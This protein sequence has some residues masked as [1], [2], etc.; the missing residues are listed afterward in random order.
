[1][2]TIQN[3]TLV[4]CL[5][6]FASTFSTSAHARDEACVYDKKDYE[7]DELCLSKSVGNLADE[8]WNDAI[9][10]I[11][12]HG[13]TEVILYEHADYKG[14]S[15]H[16]TGSASSLRRGMDDNVSSIEI[17]GTNGGDQS[18]TS[19]TALS[20]KYPASQGWRLQKHCNCAS[21]KRCYVRN[22]EVGACITECPSGCKN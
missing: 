16:L 13:D 20:R 19:D 10:S 11:E 9:S 4:L 12:I 5:G 21:G 14:K 6:L 15:L 17:V 18:V 7:G 2:R 1:M 22:G 8:G 3:T